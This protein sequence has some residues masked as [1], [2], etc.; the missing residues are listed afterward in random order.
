MAFMLI[1]FSS[2]SGCT[3][4]S[5]SLCLLM[6]SVGI[7][8]QDR[9]MSSGSAGLHKLFPEKRDPAVI[10]MNRLKQTRC[11]VRIAKLGDGVY[12]M[13]NNSPGKTYDIPP[14]ADLV[15]SYPWP[16]CMP[17]RA[18]SGS[19]SIAV[20]E[21]LT[22]KCGA[23][24]LQGNAVDE[25]NSDEEDEFLLTDDL[26][27]NLTAPPLTAARMHI[28]NTKTDGKERGC[29]WF[30]SP[31]RRMCMSRPSRIRTPSY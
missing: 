2:L 6:S 5:S 25:C 8:L 16:T 18:A 31:V 28:L 29:K 23:L 19:S 7:V 17:L 20:W 15:L 1:S 10:M 13:A 14:V 3:H 24:R 21:G 4:L 9:F 26:V 22:W 12:G 27:R 30:P 11:V